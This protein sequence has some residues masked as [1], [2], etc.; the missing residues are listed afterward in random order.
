MLDF[1]GGD[2]GLAITQAAALTGLVQ[3]GLRQSAEVA[4]QAMSVERVLEYTE[5]PEEKQPEVPKTPKDDW[6]QNGR[7]VF[8][9]MGLRYSSDSPLVIKSL[10]LVIQ[11]KEKVNCYK[12]RTFKNISLNLT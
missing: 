4:N 10:D 8:T 5:L 1:K 7:L 11:S 3:W 9:K 12:I 2:V 6:P